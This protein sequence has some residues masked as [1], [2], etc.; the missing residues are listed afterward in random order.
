MISMNSTQLKAALECRKKWSFIHDGIYMASTFPMARGT[1]IHRGRQFNLAQKKESNKDRPLDEV[2]DYTVGQIREIEFMPD[3][4]GLKMERI[5]R[6]AIEKDYHVYQ[7]KSDPL[8]VEEKIMVDIEDLGFRLYGTLDL[9]TADGE[10][11]D[12]KTV[13]RRKSPFFTHRSRQ[14]TIYDMLA[15][16]AGFNP[17]GQCHQFLECAKYNV[18]ANTVMTTRTPEDRQIVLNEIQCVVEGIQRGDITGAPDDSWFCPCQF[19]AICPFVTTKAKQ[20]ATGG[21]SDE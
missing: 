1:L 4:D 14:L 18:T 2:L 6:V 13:S 16:K 5:V 9:F 3:R 19:A 20:F 17:R 15:R 11:V 8:L 12:L 7:I 10:V 21:I